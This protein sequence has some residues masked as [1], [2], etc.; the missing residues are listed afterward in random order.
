MRPLYPALA[1]GRDGPICWI[2]DDLPGMGVNDQDGLA[3]L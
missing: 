1:N 3:I 2:E